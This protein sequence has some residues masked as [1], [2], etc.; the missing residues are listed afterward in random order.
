M[1]I[2]SQMLLIYPKTSTNLKAFITS[3]TSDWRKE[4]VDASYS[5]S[6]LFQNF[7]SY[8]F[9]RLI[10]KHFSR[11]VYIFKSAKVNQG[12]N[13]FKINFPVFMI[14]N[15]TSV[16]KSYLKIISNALQMA[17]LQIHNILRLTLSWPWFLSG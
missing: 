8:F 5:S 7:F 11:L 16:L 1:V 2:L 17:L 15:I 10:P 4:L 3:I 6:R 12:S 14:Q 9:S 13:F